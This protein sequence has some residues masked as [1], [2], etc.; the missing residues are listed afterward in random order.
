VTDAG[1]VLLGFLIG[2]VSGATGIGGGTLLA[3]FL[4][5]VLKVDPFVSV[6]TDLFVSVVTKALGS[7]IHKRA[8]NVEM[9]SVRPLALAGVIGGLI[10]IVALAVLKTHVDVH[11][12]QTVLRHV[13]GTTLCICAIAIAISSRV[14]SRHRRFDNAATLGV[15]GGVVSAITTVTGVGVG[16]LSVPALYFIKGRAGMSSIVGTSL[17]YATIVTAIGAVG[18][19]V[20]GDVNYGLAALL[21]LGSLPGVTLGSA[22]ATRAPAALKPLIVTLLVLCGIRLVA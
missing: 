16:S 12:G 10:G 17:I 19:I 18:H 1:V 7:V 2:V 11:A 9:A 22:F 4:M 13:I 14:R 6:G 3:P 8:D 15:M 5:F 21:L 20:F